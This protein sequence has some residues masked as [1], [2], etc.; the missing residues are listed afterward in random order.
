MPN[1]AVK[2]KKGNTEIRHYFGISSFAEC[3]VCTPDC[4][5]RIEK[6]TPWDVASIMGCAVVTGVGAVL[7]TAKVRPGQTVAVF[8]LGGVGLSAVMAARASGAA[9]I[10]GI[11]LLENKFPLARE[12]G[13]TDVF[14]AADPDL[15]PKILDMTNG[16]VDFAFEVSGAIPALTTAN[17][18]T[19]KGAEV[20]IVGI[21]NKGATYQ[22]D[23]LTTIFTERVYRGSMLGSGI[24]MR[25]I[26][27]YERL[28][29]KGDL[30]LQR[31]LSTEF[32][33]D[34]LN[35]GFDRLDR[36][37]VVRQVLLPHGSNTV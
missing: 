21:P 8:G 2:M 35:A 1:G 5:I 37:E 33:F 26:P 11:D 14:S 4:L 30:P 32:G 16:G 25:D 7:G 20:I 22:L 19:A 18:I 3:A 27:V 17:A 23:P 13:C 6:E 29:L 24:P 34:Q 28:Y 31:L 10:I 15:V 12:S 36:G 9:Q